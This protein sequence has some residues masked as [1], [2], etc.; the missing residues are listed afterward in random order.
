MYLFNRKKVNELKNELQLTSSQL[1]ATKFLLDDLKRR[2]V[3]SYDELTEY[4]VSKYKGKY[5]SCNFEHN[6]C[7]FQC[8]D[9]S[10]NAGLLT[11]DVLLDDNTKSKYVM[12]V[13]DLSELKNSTKQ[14]FIKK[15]EK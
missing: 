8:L 12:T 1:K 13:K 4:F 7:I 5:F 10:Y 11:L 15:G 6:N 9:I 14:Q 2:V 3:N